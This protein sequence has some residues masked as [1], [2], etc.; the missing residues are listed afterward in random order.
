M[1]FS[2]W[3]TRRCYKQDSWGN[4]LVVG[5]LLAGEKVSTE[6]EDIAEIRHQALTG[7]DTAHRL[8]LSTCCS[9]LQSL[10]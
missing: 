1:V 2:V 4:E 7:E 9:E 10:N 6:A 5:Q 8:R 3:S